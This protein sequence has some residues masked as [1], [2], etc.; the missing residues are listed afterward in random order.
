MTLPIY[1]KRDIDPEELKRYI[2]YEFANGDCI[3]AFLDILG[4]KEHVR[5][6]VNPKHP[7]DKEILEKIKSAL[8]DSFNIIRQSEYRDLLRIKV[9][10]DCTCAS[11]PAMLCTPTEASML[12][13]L[14]TWAGGY[15]FQLFR[16]NIYPRG[17]ISA[18]F[19]YEDE[20][21]IFSDGLIKAYEL[22][23]KRA[24][25]PRTILDEELVQRLKWLWMDQRDT[26][27]LFGTNKKIIVD[28][29][30]IALIN[31]FNLIQSTDKGNFEEIKKQFNN[32]NDFK[33]YLLSIDNKYNNE[34]LKNLEDKIEQY[35]DDNHKQIKYLWL[36]DL[37]NWNMDPKSSEHKFEY[38][39]KY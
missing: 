33:A 5:K 27:E 35:K 9:F 30:G 31:P 20:N 28:E 4:F 16:R 15:N 13:S 39:L 17:G 7:Q 1:R 11:M 2:D 6:Y 22:E 29:E 37:L 3:V 24:I 14:I 25:Y 32:K 34:I 23:N 18:G 38:L 36:K 12:C 21:M 26:I 10:S 19:H 8:N